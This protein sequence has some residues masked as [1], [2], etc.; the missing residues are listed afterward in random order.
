MTS[1]GGWDRTVKLL[2]QANFAGATPPLQFPQDAFL[3]LCVL[4][5]APIVRADAHIRRLGLLIIALCVSMRAIDGIGQVPHLPSGVANQ[6]PGLFGN[7]LPEFS[8]HRALGL[9]D[10]CPLMIGPRLKATPCVF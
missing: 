3:M 5:Q 10:R 7:S 6:L 2:I 8:H 4:E 9:K 1:L